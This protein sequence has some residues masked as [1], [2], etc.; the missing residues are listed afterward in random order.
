MLGSIL[1]PHRDFHKMSLDFLTNIEFWKYLS[2]PLVAG[3]VGWS[4]NWVAIKLLFFPIEPIGKPPWLGWQGILPSKAEKMG[5]ITVD[6]T[7]S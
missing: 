4:T 2:I 3:F 7:L 6:T 1:T 5:A